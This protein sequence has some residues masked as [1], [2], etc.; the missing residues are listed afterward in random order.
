M[1]KNY[2]LPYQG[3]KNTIIPWLMAQLPSAGTFVDLFAGGCSVSHAAIVSGKYKSVIANDITDSAFVFR[4]AVNGRFHN[5]RRW[6]SRDDFFRLKDD[7]PYVR[8]CFSFGN[9][10]R[11][12]IYA[13]E[14]ESYKE[15]CHYAIVF[16]D[17]HK[18]KTLCPEVTS[19]IRSDLSALH[20]DY[21]FTNGAISLRRITF[22]NSLL[23]YARSL[24]DEI[25][26]KNALYRQCKLGGGYGLDVTDIPVSLQSRTFLADRKPVNLVRG[27]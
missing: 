4:D 8:L 21:P 24:D 2:G 10:Q 27:G 26:K 11:S 6:I 15:A 19:H 1:I 7:D 13:R 12:Y 25:L 22:G 3:S 9:D 14:L 23:H 16:D 20:C 5:E 18:L 17:W